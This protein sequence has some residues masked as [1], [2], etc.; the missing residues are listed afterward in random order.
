MVAEFRK[1]YN[2]AFYRTNPAAA[3]FV[4]L[5]MESWQ[6]GLGAGVALSRFIIFLLAACFWVGRIDEVFLAENVRIGTYAFDMLP[7]HFRKELFVHEAHNHPYIDRLASMYLMKLK[8]GDTF[9]N[10]AGSAWRRLF[11]NALVPWTAK[12][13]L[14]RRRSP[15]GDE[16]D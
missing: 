16:E 1:R 5:L 9:I 6:L 8:Y 11:V 4:A 10:D 7:F 3:N 14:R 15:D 12:L 13:R 2:Q